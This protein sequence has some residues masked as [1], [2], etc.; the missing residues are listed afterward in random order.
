MAALA[1]TAAA[2][3]L[4]SVPVGLLETIVAS[5]G[6]SEVL[7]A[8]APPLGMAARLSL[9]GFAG[10]LAVGIVGIMRRDPQHA[11]DDIE[12]EGR[13][14]RAQGAR[15]MGFAFSKLTALARGRATPLA[16]PAAPVLRRADAHPDAPPRPPIFAS[17]D[18]DGVEIFA[19]RESGRRPIVVHSEPV[20]EPSSPMP[21]F[22]SLR[23]PMEQAADLEPHPAFQRA[24][25]AAPVEEALEAVMDAVE[26]SFGPP[27]DVSQAIGTEEESFPTELVEEPEVIAEAIIPDMIGTAVPE[28]LTPLPLPTHGLSIA[29]LTDRLERGLASRRRSISGRP[30]GVLADMPVAS[31]VPVREAVAPDADEALRAAL[32]TLR[33]MAAR[34]R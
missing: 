28:T 26:P 7:P 24:A 3:A 25:F 21:G 22:P 17:R 15:K 18:F 33:T 2:I 16:E 1:G 6:L 8:A 30:T 13:S 31:R 14:E 19:R 32:G 11:D 29:Q 9:A 23:T 34:P 5:S 10:L 27:E 4:I 12:E 20:S